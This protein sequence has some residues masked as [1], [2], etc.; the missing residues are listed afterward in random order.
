MLLIEDAELSP[1]LTP[2]Q[3]THL[4]L[5]KATLY[6]QSNEYE[7]AANLFETLVNTAT[8]NTDSQ[9]ITLKQQAIRGLACSLVGSTCYWRALKLCWLNRRTLGSEFLLDLALVWFKCVPTG[10]IL[11][12]TVISLVFLLLQKLHFS[13][14]KKPV[15]H[16]RVTATRATPVLLHSTDAP[17]QSDIVKPDTDFRKLYM[18]AGIRTLKRKSELPDID[19]QR[20]LFGQR[21]VMEPFLQYS[22]LDPYKPLRNSQAGQ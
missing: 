18:D 22:I 9:L 7:I 10:H 4:Q 11:S 19:G 20:A 21:V 14:S 12:F 3:A 5:L 2:L 15:N 16:R 1:S 6:F 13:R 8:D 17:T